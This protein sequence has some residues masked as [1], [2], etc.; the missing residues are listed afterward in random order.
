[1]YANAD[2]KIALGLRLQ[3]TIANEDDRKAP[4]Q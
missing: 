2:K 3:K 1:M 4:F